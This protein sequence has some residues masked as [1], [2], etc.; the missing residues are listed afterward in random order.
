[1]ETAQ[2]ALKATQRF[3]FFAQKI[4]PT[5]RP[6]F[7]NSLTPRC[8]RCAISAKV[9]GISLDEGACNKCR[10]QSSPMHSLSSEEGEEQCRKLDS[11]LKDY[12]QKGEGRYD[13]LVVFSGGKDSTYL[14]Y[15]LK[16]DYPLLRVLATTWDN[17][18][19]SPIALDTAISVAKKLDIDHIL[20]KPASRVYGKMYQYSLKRVEESGSYAA[21]DAIDGALNQHIGI[22]MAAQM[23]IPIF[24]TGIERAQALIM[25]G[26]S[27]FEF[28]KEWMVG[29]VDQKNVEEKA[30]V[31]LA[32]IF[33]EDDLKLWWDGDRLDF[34]PIVL[35]PFIAWHPSHREI[36]EELE[37]ND[38]VMQAHLSPLVTN[39][40]VLPIMSAVDIAK[41]GYCSFE[42]EFSEM[43]RGGEGDP[44]Y[45]R[46]VFELLEFSVNRGLFLNKA[47]RATLKRLDLTP[48]EIGL[49]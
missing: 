16:R 48:E 35:T 12:Q 22:T 11:M 10:D 29:R 37:K 14:L 27:T 33:T 21:V 42:P 28:P 7:R 47:Y 3:E 31:K 44:I 41:I 5:I 9:P 25:G 45:W 39:N 2:A 18:F 26:Y 36:R 40:E 23:K 4:W 24:I 38:L 32:D 17:G 43:I 8:V 15:R 46:N 30:G 19:Y 6:I 1:M 13:A 49:T 34:H 20:Y